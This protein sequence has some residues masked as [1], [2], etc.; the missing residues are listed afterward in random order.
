MGEKGILFLG[1]LFSWD[2]DFSVIREEEKPQWENNTVSRRTQI[3][4]T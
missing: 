3:H 4:S 2:C 1:R